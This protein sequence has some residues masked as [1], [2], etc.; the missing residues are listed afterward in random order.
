MLVEARGARPSAASGWHRAK[1]RCGPA[2]NWIA[3][4]VHSILNPKGSGSGRQLAG[5]ARLAVELALD[6]A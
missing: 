2:S 6:R 5:R 1:V 3:I 4:A